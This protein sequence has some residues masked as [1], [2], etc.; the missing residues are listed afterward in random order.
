MSLSNLTVAQ[1]VD[2]GDAVVIR[3]ALV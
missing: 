2:E 1:F 3:A